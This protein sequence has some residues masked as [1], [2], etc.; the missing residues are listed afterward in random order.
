MFWVSSFASWAVC[1]LLISPLHAGSQVHIL[2]AVYRIA[3]AGTVQITVFHAFLIFVAAEIGIIAL[4][5]WKPC[6]FAHLIPRVEALTC[7]GS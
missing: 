1:L 2:T 5:T 6:V 3:S 4:V 7:E